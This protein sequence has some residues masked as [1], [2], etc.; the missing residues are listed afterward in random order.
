MKQKILCIICFLF[1]LNTSFGQLIEDSEKYRQQE[2]ICYNQIL[3]TLIETSITWWGTCI[4]PVPPLPLEAFEQ[5]TK[6]DSS[7]YY[8]VKSLYDKEIKDYNLAKI[9]T[10]HISD[11]LF[12]P[13]SFKSIENDSCVLHNKVSYLNT[14][15][16]TNIDDLI[17]GVN[18]KY[19]EFES[20]PNVKLKMALSRVYFDKIFLEGTFL[21]KTKGPFGHEYTRCVSVVFDSLIWRIKE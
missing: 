1:Q 2:V 12:A 8:Q 18:N 10:I 5:P 7:N 14:R 19:Y 15:T 4:I 3:E 9:I 16:I 21:L 20:N 11:S 17:K 6:L 13:S